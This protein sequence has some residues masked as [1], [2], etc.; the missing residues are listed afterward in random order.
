MSPALYQLSYPGPPSDHTRLMIIIFS[1]IWLSRP[2]TACLLFHVVADLANCIKKFK[3]II[4]VFS[5]I[6]ISLVTLSKTWA[7]LAQTKCTVF[8]RSWWQPH[9]F[10]STPPLWPCLALKSVVGCAVLKHMHVVWSL[11]TAQIQD[12]LLVEC[13]TCDWRVA[14][15]NPC[16]S[17][18]RIFFST[19]NFLCW[20]LFSVCCIHVLLQ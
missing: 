2:M 4:I 20:L 18:R 11:E 5:C 1:N 17:G 7:L 10:S 8:S 19:V 6:W 9:S 15:L 3:S 13:Q 14:G 12:G 16:R